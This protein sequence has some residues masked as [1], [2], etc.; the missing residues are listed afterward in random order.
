MLALC[1]HSNATRAPI[2]NLPNS[3]QLGGIPYYSP[4]LHPGP[5]NS[6]GMR[7]RTD[8]QTHR[9]AWP[10][11]ISRRLQRRRNVTRVHATFLESLR[12]RA[13]NGSWTRDLLITSPTSYP[14]RLRATSS[15]TWWQSNHARRS[16]INLARINTWPTWLGGGNSEW[17][18]RG[19]YTA[20]WPPRYPDIYADNQLPSDKNTPAQ[21]PPDSSRW[22]ITPPLSK[23]PQIHC[24][25]HLYSP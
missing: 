16:V 2:A 11:Y 15:T 10:Q 5:C 22:T 3:A 7:P 19:P 9:R 18:S 17:K 1:C 23:L 8:R 25:I 13:Q 6:V 20:S 12:R 14:L 21:L 24:N 4:K